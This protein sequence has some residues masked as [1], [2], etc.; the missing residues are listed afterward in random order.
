MIIAGYYSNENKKRVYKK[1]L[2]DPD[3]LNDKCQKVYDELRKGPAT[4]QEIAKAIGMETSS[5]FARLNELESAERVIDTK[6]KKQNP[7]T[8]KP[9]TI[10][11]ILEVQTKLF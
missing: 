4:A 2:A 10:Y 3:Y 7:D 6:E 8:K 9:N 1:L 11:R 5:V